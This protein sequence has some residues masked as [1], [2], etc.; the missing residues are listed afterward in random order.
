M[1]KIGTPESIGES[2]KRLILDRLRIKGGMSRADLTRETKMSFPAVSSNIKY[3]LSKE[4]IREIGAG[5]NS[6]GKKSRLLTFNAARGHVLGIDIGRHEIRYMLADLLGATVATKTRATKPDEKGSKIIKS[7]IGVAKKLVKV[8]SVE[9]GRIFAV[10]VGIP[11]I[12][13]NNQMFVA[14]YISEFSLKELRDSLESLSGANVIVE[15]G[16]NLGAIGESRRGLGA[17]YSDFVYVG[18]GVGLGAALI[19]GR[20]LYKGANDA[21]GEMGFMTI[22]PGWLR[23]RFSEIGAL[24]RRISR[25]RIAEVLPDGDFMTEMGRLLHG[26]RNSRE[27]KL[28]E[29]ISLYFGM[30]LVDVTALINPQAIIISGGIGRILGERFGAVWERI[31]EKHLPFPPEVVF[32][33]MNGREPLVGA[34]QTALEHVY[35]APITA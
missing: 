14:P 7:V 17:R 12:I 19:L 30:A 18:Y 6:V 21:A 28:L 31:L 24:E 33:N 1:T 34:L 27:N 20:K 3:L 22:A 23:E 5:G 4:Y 15:N 29:D 8:S 25:E 11:G 16:V 9:A 32:S 10:C 35:K 13:R 2:N 26:R